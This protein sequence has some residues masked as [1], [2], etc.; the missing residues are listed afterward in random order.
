[1]DV[2]ELGLNATLQNGEVTARQLDSIGQKGDRAAQL[3]ASGFSKGDLAIIKMAD[4]IRKLQGQ[5]DAAGVSATRMAAPGVTGFRQMA[6]AQGMVNAEIE[7]TSHLSHGAIIGLGELARG[8]SNVAQSGQVGA[9]SIREFGGA[10]TRLGGPLGVAVVLGGAL[11]EVL[12]KA[13]EEQD[14]LTK[15]LEDWYKTQSQGIAGDRVREIEAEVG[16]LTK[17]NDAYVKL[18][19]NAPAPTIGGE[20]GATI[21][22]GALF[23]ANDAKNIQLKGGALLAAQRDVTAQLEQQQVD[24][25][26]A[27]QRN[28]RATETETARANQALIFLQGRLRDGLNVQGDQTATTNERAAIAGMVD[29]LLDASKAPRGLQDQIDKQMALNSAIGG[30]AAALQIIAVQQDGAAQK[31]NE[32]TRALD[33]LIDRLTTERVRAIELADA[34]AKVLAGYAQ[35]NA[36]ATNLGGAMLKIED[37]VNEFKELQNAVAQTKTDLEQSQKE[38]N[39][40][41][42]KA[43]EWLQLY[44]AMNKSEQSFNRAL[45][46]D[47]LRAV[48]TIASSGL[49]SWTDFFG[50]LEHITASFFDKFQKRT[51]DLSQQLAK[52]IEAH[53]DDLASKLTT[54]LASAQKIASILGVAAAGVTGFSAGQS[55]GSIT[56]GVVSGAAAGAFVG[57]SVFPGFG[58]LIGGLAGLTGGLLGG[59]KAAKERKAAEEELTRQYDASIDSVRNQVGDLSD[60]DYAKAQAKT[61]ADQQRAQALQLYGNDSNLNKYFGTTLTR[62]PDALK[63]IQDLEDKRIKQIE[64]EAA[65][66]KAAAQAARDAANQDAIQNSQLRIYNATGQTDAAFDFQQF[67]ELQKATADGLSGLALSDIIQAQAAEKAQREQEKQTQILQDQLS[68]AQA[69]YDSAKQAYDSLKSFSDSLAIGQYSPLSPRQQLDASHSQLDAVYQAA[70]GGDSSAAQQFGGVAQTYLD[71]SRKYNAS[72]AGYVLDYNSVNVMTD[73]LKNAYGSQMTDAQKQVSLLQQQLDALN[74]IA[75]NTDPDRPGLVPTVP[76]PTPVGG[77]RPRIDGGTAVVNAIA[78]LNDRLDALMSANIDVMQAGFKGTIAATQENTSAV[79]EN[80]TLT[81]RGLQGVQAAIR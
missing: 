3:I 42:A 7:A 70:L 24:G 59:S 45:T 2:A 36:A 46:D 56:T 5:L 63:Q 66:T 33:G 18:K 62:L 49:K 65:A 71:A 22:F 51:D 28:N 23:G 81:R 47:G 15:S 26:V 31:A 6:E 10:A 39:S 77:T 60:V 1:M 19:Q 64:D 20:G 37:P 8:F 80:T 38:L 32:H 9:L 61:L 75:T 58:A 27:L 13:T 12:Q 73:A 74:K 44:D 4:D 41:A 55:S 48:Q 16:S 68:T 30:T 69:A 14:K 50:S 17:L 43:K 57:N 52:A 72:G 67:L 35:L 76:T 11:Y 21:D 25:L 40:M 29:E 79:E 78:N 53:A 34:H 54:E